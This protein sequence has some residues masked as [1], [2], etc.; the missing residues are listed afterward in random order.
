MFCV[1]IIR[2]RDQQKLMSCSWYIF[3]ISVHIERI[4]W[5]MIGSAHEVSVRAFK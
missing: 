3:N 1:I 2:L 4:Y 5:R